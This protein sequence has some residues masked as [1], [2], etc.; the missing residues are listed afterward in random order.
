MRKADS[1]DNSWVSAL[2][3]V[4]RLPPARHGPPETAERGE[5]SSKNDRKVLL[6]CKM[7]NI[8]TEWLEL[9]DSMKVNTPLLF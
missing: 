2:L 3:I 1:R 4:Y 8:W 6:C 5:V 9:T 7:V